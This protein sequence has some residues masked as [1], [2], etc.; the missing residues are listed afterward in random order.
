MSYIHIMAPCPTGWGIATD[1]TIEIAKEAVD[2]GLWMLSE[3]EQG[4]YKLNR[5]PAEFSDVRHYIKSQGRFKHLKDADIAV[6]EAYRDK[7]WA[8]LNK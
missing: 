6:I 4:S 3:Y 8:N 5:K 7:Q 1:Q 2:C